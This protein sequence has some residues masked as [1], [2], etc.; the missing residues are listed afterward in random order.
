MAYVVPRDVVEAFYRAYASRDPIQIGAMLD[1][2]IEWFVGGPTEVMQV[3]GIWRGK[4]AVIDR[5]SSFIPKVI[6]FKSLHI[7][8]L[9][10]DG[11][12]AP[13]S[14]GLPACTARPAVKS[15]I[16]SRIWCA[17]ATAR[18]STTAP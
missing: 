6:Q 7:E 4:Q 18:S 1:D 13:C 14:A 9:L 8:T 17:I 15:A 12:T 5:F 3:C 2:D 11:D 16:V 10:V